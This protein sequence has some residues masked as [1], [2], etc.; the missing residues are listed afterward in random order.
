VQLRRVLKRSRGSEVLRVAG[1]DI[2]PGQ[3]VAIVGRSGSGKSTL[4]R[5]L[6]G[7]EAPTEGSI[8]IDGEEA[9]GRR[10]DTRVLL[11]QS[12]LSPWRRVKDN[13]TAGLARERAAQSTGILAEVG[14]AEHAND[15]PHRLSAGQRQRVALARALVRGPRLLL[16]DEPL[17]TL[18]A[19]TRTEMLQLVESMWLRHGF[20]AL[21]VTHD[22]HEAVSVAERVIVMEDGH[23]ALD[24]AVPQARPRLRAD[25]QLA[26]VESRVLARVLQKPLP[27]PYTGKSPTPGLSGGSYARLLSKENAMQLND[28]KQRVDRVEE[29][30]DE[31]ERAM[32]SASVPGELRQSIDQMH[33]Q[34]RQVQQACSSQTQQ[35]DASSLRDPVMQLEQ[36]ADRAM[37]ACRNAGNVDPNLQQAIQRAHQ[38]ASGLKK[39]LQM[40]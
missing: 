12:R 31:A 3:F 28:V 16:L 7:L 20:T 23:V 25:A 17:G 22:V 2:E 26:A 30:A 36:A 5:L 18:D 6:A 13:V 11:Q 27:Q 21:L 4:L 39:Q 19:H 38:E 37:Q 29:C 8:R 35:G 10:Q 40:G 24:I 14:L 32:Q 15:W 34:A 1:L 33:Q 9:A